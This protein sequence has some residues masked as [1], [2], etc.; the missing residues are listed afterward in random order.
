[1]AL[2]SLPEY[3]KWIRNI[4]KY[5]KNIWEKDKKRDIKGKKLWKKEEKSRKMLRNRLNRVSSLK[6]L[7]NPM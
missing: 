1:M 7:I 2:H 3:K 6:K 5:I 4:L